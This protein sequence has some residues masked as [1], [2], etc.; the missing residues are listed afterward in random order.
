MRKR[1]RHDPERPGTAAEGERLLRWLGAHPVVPLVAILLLAV[2]VRTGALLDWLESAYRDFLVFDESVY[3]LWA[4]RVAQGGA[5]TFPVTDFA[6]LPAYLMVA[7][8]QAFSP[9][10]LVVRILNL[11]LGVATC[12][13]IYLIGRRLADHR[14]GLLAAAVA[15][16]YKPFIFYSVTL[17]K[18]TL[19]LLLF[20][21][22]LVLL[23]AGMDRPSLRTGLLLGAAAGLLINV[24]QNMVVILPLLPV[25]LLWGGGGMS[26]LRTRLGA[27]GGV[28]LGLMLALA[29]FALQQRAVTGGWGLTPVGGFNL[30]LGNNLDNPYPYYRPV[31]F[32]SSV[33]TDQG[34]HFV[35]EASRREGRRLTPAEASRYWTREAL[36]MAWERP[37]EFALKAGRK[38]LTVFNRSEA[39]DNYHIGFTSR[40]V[41]FLRL[42]FPAVW[43]VLPLGMA[44]MLLALGRSRQDQAL[45]AI[46]AVY[47]LSLVAFFSNARIR[48]PLLVILIPYAVLGVSWCVSAVRVRAH[49]RVGLY[50]GLVGLFAALAFFPVPGGDDMTSYYNT[51]ALN[52][53]R[54][55]LIEEAA[56][57][58]QA[59]AA[60]NRPYS[61]YARL[62]LAR[63]AYERGDLERGD[64]YLARVGEDSFAAA[65]KH[66]LRGD[67]LVR[68]G[69]LPEAMAAYAQALS[70][71]G[72]LRNA[73]IK[74]IR[75]ARIAA[76]E[77]A[78][79]EEAVLREIES[80]YPPGKR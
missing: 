14:T 17:L 63:L 37:G 65:Q 42:P 39:E 18:E 62:A 29:P 23:L 56:Q 71:N 33:P 50:A 4:V 52:L 15:A 10:P 26:G 45:A 55:G 51:H 49:R 34:V 77:V 73:R 9:Q 12:G 79:R 78:A 35:I 69:R 22:V 5:A 43:C 54:K 74:L 20:A 28:A 64:G 2:L 76:P 57:Y 75:A 72:G 16:L 7:A 61:A 70:I 25:I 27:A 21:G 11:L 31:R 66:E 58:W 53:Q 60:M 40:F 3:H 13:G 80:F 1:K 30:Y 68:R 38:A 67:V 24:R 59:S 32:A 19:G 36:R 48:L 6:S 47:A 46:F 41:P 8:Y 44:G